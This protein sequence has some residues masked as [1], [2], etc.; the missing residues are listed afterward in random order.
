MSVL[1][2]RA[3]AVLIGALAALLTV[4]AAG[5]PWIEGTV[6]D[7]MIGGSL[8][9]VGGDE[10][11]TGIVALGLVLLAGA[12]AAAATRT[13]GRR[14]AAVILLLTALFLGA[15]VLRVIMDPSAIL[16]SAAA[17][18]TGRTGS[19]TATGEAT[20][21]AYLALVPALLGL[22]LA[23]LAWRGATAWP[24]P[25]SAYDRPGTERPGKRGERVTSDWER[26][27]EGEDPTADAG[28]V[29][30]SGR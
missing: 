21:W 20:G 22:V 15:L 8:Q 23:A 24:Q 18:D 6:D 7:A 2:R 26:L 11:V 12:V 27:S 9:Q 19:L 4:I 28:A 10:A 16:G 5:R 25:S 1:T 17:A 14:V 13:V 3:G 29:D 30:G